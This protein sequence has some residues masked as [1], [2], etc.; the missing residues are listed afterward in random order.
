MK[1][2]NAMRI[3]DGLKI[4][5]EVLTYD[6]DGEHDLPHGAAAE[7]ARKLG[8][9][10][11]GVYKT[12]VMRANTGEVLV[13]CQRADKEIN[14][15]K[16]RQAAGVESLAAVKSDELPSLTGYVRGGCSPVGMKRRLRTFIDFSAMEKEKV[17]I[18]AGIR[19]EQLLLSPKDLCNATAAAACDLAL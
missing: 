14:L 12:I 4:K 8:V 16:A 13:F 17:C 2:T 9:D 19:G 18:S 3:L 10:E 15:K 5:Y 1:K 7:T 11:Q 6:D